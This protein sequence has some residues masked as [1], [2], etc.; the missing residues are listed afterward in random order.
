MERADRIYDHRS[1]HVT[2]QRA[3]V[4]PKPAQTSFFLHTFTLHEN[5]KGLGKPGEGLKP[6]L[7]LLGT[8]TAGGYTA[9][10]ARCAGFQ[11]S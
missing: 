9:S 7:W 10:V 4:F 11:A 8:L 2:A 3:Q 1:V 5:L 6:E